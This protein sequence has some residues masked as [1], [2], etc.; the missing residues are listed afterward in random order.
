MNKNIIETTAYISRIRF[1]QF[2]E[3]YP[4]VFPGCYE[5]DTI[6]EGFQA[7]AHHFFISHGSQVQ[8]GLL[9]CPICNKTSEFALLYSH[10]IHHLHE[11]AP[12]IFSGLEEEK[13]NNAAGSH[14]SLESAPNDLINVEVSLPDSLMLGAHEQRTPNVQTRTTDIPHTDAR[15][16]LSNNGFTTEEVNPFLSGSIENFPGMHGLPIESGLLSSASAN[17]SRTISGSS[18]TPDLQC[19]V[20]RPKEV[21]QSSSNPRK[22][23]SQHICNYSGCKRTNGFSNSHDL[24]RHKR[25]V[26]GEFSGESYV[27]TVKGC[28]KRDKSWPRRDNFKTHVTTQ[29]PREPDEVD[30]VIERSRRSHATVDT[31]P[32]DHS[33]QQDNL[34]IGPRS[35]ISN[36]VAT[37]YITPSQLSQ[38]YDPLVADELE[39]MMMKFIPPGG[40]KPKGH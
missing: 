39:M 15:Q 10:Y 27:C 8:D 32:L 26:H 5:Q 31:Q 7:L 2:W 18:F 38:L 16:W 28:K 29:H 34:S 21:L 24:K 3:P 37:T 17:R 30:K 20:S 14:G 19:R 11:L 6:V 23:S 35:H 40:T 33:S 4:C 22:Q 12:T 13:S 1:T 9:N 25:S 36:D